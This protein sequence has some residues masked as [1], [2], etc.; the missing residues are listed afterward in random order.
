MPQSEKDGNG[1][2]LYSWKE[3]AI[4]L[5]ETIKT[6]QK[7]IIEIKNEIKE[8]KKI[9]Q[10]N[11]DDVLELKIKMGIIGVV[12]GAAGAGIVSLIVHLLSH[13]P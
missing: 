4:W 10:R 13:K 8:L 5:V 6:L 2:G 12:S 7:E 1:S 9:I 3:W 11:H